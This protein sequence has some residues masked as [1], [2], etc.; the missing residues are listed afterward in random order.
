MRERRGLGE[1]RAIPG[2]QNRETWGTLGRAGTETGEYKGRGPRAERSLAS[3]PYPCS[4][5]PI[6]PYS[7]FL[8]PIPYSLFL[9]PI[10]C[11]LFPAP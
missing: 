4:L 2:L 11:S 1:V 7:L 5:F 6:P 3:I 10:P 8:F 9:F